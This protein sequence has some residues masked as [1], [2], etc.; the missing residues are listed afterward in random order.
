MSIIS[1]I[2]DNKNYLKETYR[3]QILRENPNTY[4]D[5]ELNNLVDKKSEEYEIKRI[6]RVAKEE[7]NLRKQNNSSDDLPVSKTLVNQI[8]GYNI[9]YNVGK[10]IQNLSLINKDFNK[11]KFYSYQNLSSDD[12]SILK[13]FMDDNKETLP[14]KL[15]TIK[16]QN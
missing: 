7:E 6:E 3:K 5:E 12:L 4:T 2:E 10:I 8:R 14:K 15:K 13:K 9:H 1:S 16:E 11:N